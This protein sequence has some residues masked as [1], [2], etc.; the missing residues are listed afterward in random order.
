MPIVDTVR[1]LL[2]DGGQATVECPTCG[3]A[4]AAGETICGECHELVADTADFVVTHAELH[5]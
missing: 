4:L 2:A 5:Q 1:E 3:A